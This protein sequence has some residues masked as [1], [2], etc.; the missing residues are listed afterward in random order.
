[1]G[2]RFLGF[3]FR[4]QGFGFSN[5]GFCDSEEE[6]HSS[7]VDMVSNPAVSEGILRGRIFQLY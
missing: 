6:G 4:L 1:M 5:Q 3:A 7:I 2:V